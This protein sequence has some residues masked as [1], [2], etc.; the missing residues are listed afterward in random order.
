MELSLE[1]VNG[2]IDD[3][4]DELI[5]Q[6]GAHYPEIT[7]EIILTALTAAIESDYPPN[8]KLLRNSM[9]EMR[10]T[11]KIFG[12]YRNRKKVTI[13][14]SAR[15]TPEE[16]IYQKCRTFSKLLAER[17][18]M[19]ITGG[20]GGIMQAGTEG[21]GADN[22]F[23]ANIRLPF[24]QETNPV[25]KEN[26]RSIVYRYFFTRKLA[27]LNE[28]H[29]VV[30]FPGGFGTQ[31]EVMETITLV[32]T[33]KMAPVPV[34]L[35]D[36]DNGDYWENLLTFMKNTLL[37]KGLI[38]GQDFGLFTLTRDPQEAVQ[39][40]DDFYRVYHSMRFVDNI[41]IVRL[42]R[43]LTAEQV[44][45]LEEE[46]H[47]IIASGHLRQGEALPVENDQLDLMDLPRLM[48][49]FNHRCYGLLHSF[50]RRINTF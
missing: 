40:I 27:F 37:T 46:F 1:R 35:I 5:A 29:A 49:D 42:N 14:G 15:T 24:E 38:S 39:V 25:M 33:G 20:G 8:L 21:A 30:G 2:V 36:D 26:P 4:I 48:F 43:A 32:Q 7:R 19:V 45:T 31:D 50:I 11:N 12:P 28:A 16:N 10:Y 18:Y 34:V 47:D 23:A 41:L 6:T 3:R 22:S 44:A 13:F 17:G 9:Q